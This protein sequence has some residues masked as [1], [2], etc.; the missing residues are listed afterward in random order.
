MGL[1]I[2]RTHVTS[3]AGSKI[4][5]S[6]LEKAHHLLSLQEVKCAEFLRLFSD[7]HHS[8]VKGREI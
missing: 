2:L 4:W 7:A 3:N 5:G 1:G 6:P 8:S